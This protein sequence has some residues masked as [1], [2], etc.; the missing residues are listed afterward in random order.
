MH[1]GT[2]PILML[3]PLLLAVQPV[4]AHDGYSHGPMD[5]LSSLFQDILPI[6]SAA[7]QPLAAVSVTAPNGG[8]NITS[9]ANFNVTWTGS[10]NHYWVGYT[11]NASAACSNFSGNS[12]TSDDGGWICICHLTDCSS[13]KTASISVNSTTVR[14]RVVGHDGTHTAQGVD[15]S[16][17]VFTVASIPAPVS[18]FTAAKLNTSAIN[19]SWSSGP[20]TEVRTGYRIYRNGS[21]LAASLPNGTTSYLDTGLAYNITHI[22][23]ITAYNA[24]GEANNATASNTTN[25]LRPSVTLNSPAN[26]FNS[27]STLITFN[28]S[29]QDDSMLSG[30]SLFINLTGNFTQLNSTNVTGSSN[31]TAFAANLSQ[32][33]YIWSCMA[34]DNLSQ[35]SFAASNFSLAVDA[36]PPAVNLVSPQNNSIWTANHTVYFIYNVTDN[37]LLSNCSL[38]ING[39]ANS[40][41][42]NIANATSL[43]INSTLRDNYYNW[44]MQCL[45]SASNSGTSPTYLIT[46]NSGPT[47]TLNSPAGYLNSSNSTIN[48]N[49]SAFDTIGLA[50]ITLYHNMTGTYSANSTTNITGTTN[51]SNWTLN[52][53]ENYFIWSCVPFNSEN[54]ANLSMPNRSLTIDRTAPLSIQ[55]L[56][57][58]D[59]GWR[60]I[61]INW[62]VP[63]SSDIMN[64]SVY[65][66]G[67]L[68]GN[69]SA[70]SQPYNISGLSGSTAY[71]ITVYTIDYAGNVNW[72][73]ANITNITD[74]EPPYQINISNPT[75]STSWTS[76]TQNTIIWAYGGNISRFH[77]AYTTSASAACSGINETTCSTVSSWTCVENNVTATSLSWTNPSVDSSSVRIMVTGLFSN[78]TIANASCT[79]SFSIRPAAAATAAPASGGASGGGSSPSPTPMASANA[80]SQDANKTNQTQPKTEPAQE[81]Q[82]VK[83]VGEIRKGEPKSIPVNVAGVQEI[84]IYVKNDTKDAKLTVSE[85]SQ[86]PENVSL[87]PHMIYRLLD[88]SMEGSNLSLANV[89]IR[90]SV[91]AS[92]L[93][94]N[95]LNEIVLMHYRERK[96]E[97]LPTALLNK[98]N[99]TLS[100][101][102]VSESLSIFAIAGVKQEG[103]NLLLVL[104]VIVIIIIAAAI[105]IYK[106]RQSQKYNYQLK[107]FTSLKLPI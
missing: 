103:F 82:A 85:L 40:T 9:G 58:K 87:P 105:Y 99:E 8:D 2:R 33:Y 98:T 59:I 10:D 63:S 13:P 38:L 78:Y 18:N 104:A 79:S 23:N 60:W 22:Y 35:T 69:V 80:S 31:S 57:V 94:E 64:I 71:L 88:I 61:R 86:P 1:A 21:V 72:T 75:S 42:S 90:F 26:M 62:T 73:G 3:I 74:P 50:N 101:E 52:M 65:T 27:S 49:C 41:S 91:N 70:S 48:F 37:F 83:E 39:T 55:N 51:S 45:D 4:L 96:W 19:L 11:T 44:S 14:V 68:K 54:E 6:V 93:A 100:Y 24:I 56:S 107:E 76:G 36:T 17:N 15:C 67:T 84:V 92:W 53:P 32:G 77:V 16:D 102:A 20:P 25:D 28:C 34:S 106:K 47:V 5:W 12:C 43:A 97:R 46:V 30:I 66:N 95:K 7:L 29:A 81:K 89:T